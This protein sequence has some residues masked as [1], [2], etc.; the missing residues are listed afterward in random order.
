MEVG[1][2]DGAVGLVVDVVAQ[3][4]VAEVQQAADDGAALDAAVRAVRVLV[5][6]DEPAALVVNVHAPRLV[7]LACGT[8][9][10]KLIIKEKKNVL[11]T[12]CFGY[13]K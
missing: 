3:R 5:H 11:N 7:V 13:R 8:K 2:G 10:P 4:V 1:E 12:F 9:E 6:V